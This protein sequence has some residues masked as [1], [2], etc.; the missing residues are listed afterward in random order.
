MQSHSDFFHILFLWQRTDILD[1][2]STLALWNK[3]MTSN[4]VNNLRIE[5]R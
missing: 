3:E 2:E 4:A 5:G 1:K